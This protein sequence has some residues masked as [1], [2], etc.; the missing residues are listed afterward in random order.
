MQD[1]DLARL[2]DELA[3]IKPTDPSPIRR[4]RRG[5]LEGAVRREIIARGG[6]FD[7]NGIGYEVGERG[8]IECVVGFVGRPDAEGE[9]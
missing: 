7:W 8:G 5:S 4:R 1:I 3:E 6:R 2:L 9:R